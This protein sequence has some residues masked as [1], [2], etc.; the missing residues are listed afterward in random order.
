[1]DGGNVSIDT[2]TEKWLRTEVAGRGIDFKHM[3]SC[4]PG[5]TTLALVPFEEKVP[6]E[7]LDWG[8]DLFNMFDESRKALLLPWLTKQLMQHHGV[9][10][11]FGL[12]PNEIE[13]C[14]EAGCKLYQ[15]NPYHNAIHAC[16]VVQ[17]IHCFLES[18]LSSYAC[19]IQFKLTG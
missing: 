11:K 8:P 19:V 5:A 1:M 6:Q 9:W 17:T 18:G 2:E 3:K 13:S 14:L 12:D 4:S 15:E 16:D 10:G 7:L